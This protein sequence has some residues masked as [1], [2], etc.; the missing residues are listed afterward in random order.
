M[1]HYIYLYIFFM[2]S[3]GSW[4]QDVDATY[5]LQDCITIAI[6]NNLDLKSAALETESADV[7]FKQSKN[8]LLPTLNGNYDLGR[9]SGRSIDPFTN[10][11]INEQLTFS[12]ASLRL[13]ATVFNGFR[14][15]NDWRQKKLNLLASEME[16][17]VARQNLILDVTLAYLQ[18]MNSRDLFKLAENRY[19]STSQQL[20]R[21]KSMFDEELGNPAEYRDFQGLRANDEAN[22]IN[23]KNTFEDAKLALMQLLNIET[24]FEVTTVNVPLDSLQKDDSYRTIYEL[25]IQNLA[26]VKA[27]EYRL[28]AAKKGVAVAKAQ[29][30]PEISIFA[31]L[32][33][34]YSSAARFFNEGQTSI[35]ETGNFVTVN[36]EDFPVLTEDTELIPVEIS[37]NDQFDNNIS[38]AAGIA[39][40]VPLFNGFRAK[41]NVALE[42][43]NKDEAQI[44]LERTKLQLRTIIEQA[45]KDMVSASKRYDVLQRQVEAYEESL[46]INEILFNNGVSNSVDYIIS[47]NNLDNAQINLNNVKYE[48]ILR[49]KILDYYRGEIF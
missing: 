34:N 41:N 31:N 7:N 21:L 37:Y 27:V 32:N 39:V 44:E 3:W 28:D 12:N 24:S 26:T 20:E 2:Y 23:A 33:T 14:L 13:G 48:Y 18:V 17:E 22:L 43:I 16:K 10:S 36:N 6:Q 1:R 46:R 11:F 35:V 38:T 9:A 49:S 5:S 15:I 42:K 19:A 30:V 8:A 47:K 45:Y 40:T 4:G 29:Y 25:A